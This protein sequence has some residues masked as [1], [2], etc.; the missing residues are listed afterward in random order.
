M[1]LLAASGLDVAAFGAGPMQAQV[2]SL[3]CLYRGLLVASSDA[4]FLSLPAAS[5]KSLTV[6]LLT[7]KSLY[8]LTNTGSF[9]ILSQSKPYSAFS[10]DQLIGV[11][12]IS[13]IS[14]GI[15]VPLPVRTTNVGVPLPSIFSILCG[16]QSL[17]LQMS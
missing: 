14:Y 3:P 4:G 5:V 10:L 8:F 6:N 11:N 9:L 15:V 7:S 13:T 16:L 12:G 1:Y 2:P 17:H